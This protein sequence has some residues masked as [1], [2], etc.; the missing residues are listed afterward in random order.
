MKWGGCSRPTCCKLCASGHDVQAWPAGHQ[1]VLLTTPSDLPWQNF[2]KSWAWEQSRACQQRVV[3]LFLEAPEFPYNKLWDRWWKEAPVPKTSSIRSAVS[4]DQT[5][6][7]HRR[8]QSHGICRAK[9]A[10]RS[11][12]DVSNIAGDKKS[13][14]NIFSVNSCNRR[15]SFCLALSQ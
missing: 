13:R 2:A 12:T 7:R 5:C 9:T 10:S 8:T 4:I 11:K 1:R 15:L 14:N 3:S 6:D